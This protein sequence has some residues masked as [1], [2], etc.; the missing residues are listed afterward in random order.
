MK[1]IKMW[2]VIINTQD[3]EDLPDRS[4]LAVAALSGEPL[5]LGSSTLLPLFTKCLFFLTVPGIKSAV[6]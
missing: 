4:Q 1:Y 3:L 6:T 2:E 5:L